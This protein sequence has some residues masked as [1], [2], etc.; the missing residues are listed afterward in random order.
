MNGCCAP[1]ARLRDDE[2]GQYVRSCLTF[3]DGVI[4]TL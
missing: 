3:W 4:R 2:A 1:S